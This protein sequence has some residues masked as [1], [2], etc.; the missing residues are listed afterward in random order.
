MEGWIRMAPKHS[1]QRQIG[2]LHI[3]KAIL[4]EIFDGPWN[5]E[6]NISTVGG[7][8][9]ILETHFSDIRDVSILV[10]IIWLKC[11]LSNF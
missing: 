9:Y 2:S 4:W 5:R 3:D 7:I 6:A 1:H 10:L 8:L 11:R